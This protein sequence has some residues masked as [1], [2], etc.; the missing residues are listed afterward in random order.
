MH[1]GLSQLLRERD[2]LDAARQHLLAQPGAGRARRPA[3][4]PLSLAGR[5]GPDP[6]GRGRPGR[7]RSTCSTRR[8]ACYVGDFSP[9]VRPVAALRARVLGRAGQVGRGA[10]LGAG[11]GPV[12]RRRPRATCASSSTSPWPGCSLARSAAERDER[13]DR[14]GDRGCWSASCAAAEDGGRTGSVIEILV[15]QALAHQA[16]GD[17]PA[18]L[19]AAATRADAGRAGGLRPDLRRRGPAHGRPAESRREARAPPRS[20]ARR[21]LAAFGRTGGR[22]ARPAGPGRAAERPR[23]GRAPAARHRPGRPGHRPRARS[24]P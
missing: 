6:R 11:A 10:R 23:A 17:L 4:E 8:S 19:G 15:L 5:D 7:R 20:Y 1:V 18:A 14:R 12:R 22:R 3:A 24:C 21:L 16:R 9:D 13:L 2:D